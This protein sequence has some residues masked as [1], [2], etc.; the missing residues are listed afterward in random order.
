[1]I[2]PGESIVLG[3][4]SLSSICSHAI[5]HPHPSV[6]QVVKE[7]YR[8]LLSPI[9]RGHGISLLPID[10]VRVGFLDTVAIRKPT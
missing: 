4:D 2:Y 5:A 1:M 10:C 7:V 3:C 9:V 6:S 8:S